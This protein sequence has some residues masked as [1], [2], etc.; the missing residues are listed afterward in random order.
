VFR[1]LVLKVT[2]GSICLPLQDRCAWSFRRTGFNILFR[3]CLWRAGGD[4]KLL[5]KNAVVI[6]FLR[7]W[8]LGGDGLGCRGLS[9]W[10]CPPRKRSC[11]AGVCWPAVALAGTRDGSVPWH[12]SVTSN[13]ARENTRQRLDGRVSGARSDFLSAS[14]FPCENN[15]MI[16]NILLL[17][18]NGTKQRK[19]ER[20]P[21]KAPMPL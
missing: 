15:S 11:P 3:S 14:T 10:S 7:C 12:Y 20:R 13:H 18:S 19:C 16:I 9:D 17:E 5:G 1:D 21:Q 4:R 8:S 6:A 2:W